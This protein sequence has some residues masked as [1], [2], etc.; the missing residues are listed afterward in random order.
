MKNIQAR[1]DEQVEALLGNLNALV[2]ELAT[3]AIAQRMVK[4]SAKR[5]RRR[6]EIHRTPEQIAAVVEELYAHVCRRPG[7]TMATI[8]SA[9]K[10]SAREL[11]FPMRKLITTGRVKKTGQRQFVRYFPVGQQ[12]KRSRRKTR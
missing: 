7:E 12:A 8:S 2:G 9:M 4:P 5:Q 1:I 11:A 6:S 3:E 10:Y